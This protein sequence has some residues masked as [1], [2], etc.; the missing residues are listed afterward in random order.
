MK[1]SS[2]R[3]VSEHLRVVA[4]DVAIASLASFHVNNGSVGILHGTLLDPWLDV[5]LGGQFEHFVDFFGAA[6]GAA[7]NLDTIADK[8]EGVDVRELATVRSS[9]LDKSALSLQKGDVALKGHLSAGNSGDD[10]IKSAA[11]VLC[12]VL[13]VIGS[14]V[15]VGTELEDLVLLGC[16][17]R[18]TNN[19]V[20]SKG[21]GEQDT[22]V[23]E[24]ADTND[25]DLRIVRL[26]PIIRESFKLTFLPGPA[27]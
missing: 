18:D 13:V 14:D 15:S 7:A 17:A 27:P 2:S 23:T 19:L 3:K 24:T 26:C 6:N 16:L 9:D 11:V 10:Q 4:K 5:F 21:L 22:K 12:P 8:S 25:T 1:V 20:G